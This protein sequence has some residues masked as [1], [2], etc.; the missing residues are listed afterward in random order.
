ME[1]TH[2]QRVLLG[3]ERKSSPGI[4][5]CRVA[6]TIGQYLEFDGLSY[7]KDRAAALW[8]DV[9]KVLEGKFEHHFRVFMKEEPHNP[10]KVKEGRWRLIIASAL[11]VQIAWHMVFG[12]YYTTIIDEPYS[13]PSSYGMVYPGGGW[14]MLR[15]ECKIKE[16]KYCIDKSAWDFNAPG[17]VFWTQLEVQHQLLRDNRSSLWLTYAT[18]LFEDAFENSLLHFP[19]GT[20]YRQEFSGFMKSGLVGTIDL[21]SGAQ[22]LLS[23]LATLRLGLPPKRIRATGDDTIENGP[24]D[25]AYIQQLEKA[26]CRVKCFQE[27][28]EFMGFD[29]ETFEPMYPSKHIANALL[30]RKETRKEVLDAYM[31]LYANSPMFYK[32]K[33]LMY[34]AGYTP[35]R[36]DFE[37]QYWLNN[38]M[39]QD[40]TKTWNKVFCNL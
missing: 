8:L 15:N 23:D 28:V 1:E 39:S 6:T 38:P 9:Q 31:M 13:T 26:G 11:S 5:Y 22:V 20:M 12:E 7:N 16:L 24:V 36:S 18:R 19:D 3:L 37:C 2:Y 32:W 34:A 21:N 33:A 25:E 10:K 17:W 30:S 29:L 40:A 4:P 35:S 14:R 27:A